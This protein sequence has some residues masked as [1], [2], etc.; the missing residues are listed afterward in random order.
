MLDI[1]KSSFVKEEDK[2]MNDNIEKNTCKTLV[3]ASK[4][5]FKWF[6]Y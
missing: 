4:Q 5:N 2:Q 6:N 1:I 3:K